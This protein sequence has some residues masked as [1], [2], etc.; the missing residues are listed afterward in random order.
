M[1]DSQVAHFIKQIK[2]ESQRSMDNSQVAHINEINTSLC[3]PRGVTNL[4]TNGLV[5]GDGHA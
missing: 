1:G 2:M 4:C 3:T 5:V